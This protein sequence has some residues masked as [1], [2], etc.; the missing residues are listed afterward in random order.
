VLLKSKNMQGG[1]FLGPVTPIGGNS[2]L[3]AN[4]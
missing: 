1:K 4:I 2:R 3:V